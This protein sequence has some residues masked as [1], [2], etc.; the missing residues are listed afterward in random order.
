MTHCISLTPEPRSAP[1][2][3]TARLTTEVSICA[4][5]TPS[6]MATRTR[7]GCGARDDLAN[8]AVSVISASVEN[9]HVRTDVPRPHPISASGGPL[10]TTISPQ[11]A[12]CC[13]YNAAIENGFAENKM[14]RIECLMK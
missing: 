11:H 7:M 2:F 8:V 9:L 4:I 5:S 6:D 12:R 10:P 13:G 14:G 1:I 3:F